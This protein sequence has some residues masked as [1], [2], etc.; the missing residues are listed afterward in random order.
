M[1]L[2]EWPEK[3]DSW[4]VIAKVLVEERSGLSWEEILVVPLGE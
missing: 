1:I 4:S 2:G 3:I